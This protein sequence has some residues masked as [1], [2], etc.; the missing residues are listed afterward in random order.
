MFVIRKAWLLGAWVLMSTSS[1]WA[2]EIE[3]KGDAAGK[4]TWHGYGELHY[5]SPKGSSVPK[6]GDPAIMDFHRMV[7]GLSYH[8]N[9]Q[10]SL[11]TEIDFEHAAKA[12]DLELEYAYVDFLLTPAVNLRMG[13]VLMPVGPLNEFHEPPLFYSVERP[14]VQRTIIPTT[15]QE[16]GFGIFGSPLDGAFKYRLYYV[17]TLDASNFTAEDGIRKGRGKLKEEKSNDKAL[18]GRIEFVAVPGLTLGGSGYKGGGNV[19]DVEVSI[20]EG[21]F[22]Y[23][24]GGLDIQGTYAAID[25]DG[26]QKITG[27]TVGSKMVGWT[28]EVAYH[29]LPHFYENTKKDM[30]LFVRWEEFNTQKEVV[31]GATAD[32]KNDREVWTYGVA[33]YP[34]S[35]I[36]VKTDV[37]NWKSAAGERDQRV[38]VGLAYMF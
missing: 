12:D 10:I 8:W 20:L 21:D 27:K 6:D 25:I 7:W 16:G 32:P 18:T 24:I 26:A 37:E 35:D 34:V 3:G 31:S 13:A 30:V 5:N 23:R 29:L 19:V 9:D 38:N 14:Y 33:Y 22:R 36:A 28:G 4:L 1:S 11:H 17:S 15:W 2:M